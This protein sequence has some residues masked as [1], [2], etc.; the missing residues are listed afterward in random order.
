MILKKGFLTD[1]EKKLYKKNLR[2]AKDILDR[3]CFGW[4]GRS[5]ANEHF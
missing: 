5:M 1:L 3:A 2:K 4:V